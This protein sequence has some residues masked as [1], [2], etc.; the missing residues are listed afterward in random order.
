MAPYRNQVVRSLLRVTGAA[1]VLQ[2]RR[3]MPRDRMAT[4]LV[5][6]GLALAFADALDGSRGTT[7]L[8]EGASAALRELS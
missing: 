7:A 2:V 1:V 5:L 3:A 4:S 8:L 6:G